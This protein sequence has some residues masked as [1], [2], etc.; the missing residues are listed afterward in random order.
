MI[1]N[2]INARR[3]KKDI[4]TLEENIVLLLAND[5]PEMAE[6][7]LHWIFGT[8]GQLADR[9][10]YILHQSTDNF[11]YERN[12]KKHK[13]H[14]FLIGVE[15]LNKQ[16][17]TYIP[18]RLTISNN[19]I[20]NISLPFNTTLRNEY[21]L[22]QLSI[23]NLHKE[24]FIL[25]NT[26]EIKLK[27]ILSNVSEEQKMLLEIEDTIE[28]ELDEKYYYTIMDMENGNYIAV[29]KMG[30]VFRLIHDHEEPAKKIFQNVQKL[31]EA[32]SGDKYELQKYLEQ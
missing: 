5:F 28:I 16:T 3:L 8:A 17:G 7:Y 30:N 23:N 26:D 29:N 6:N 21:E 9:T 20:Q 10:I 18:I 27:K 2:F 14:F 31:M 4:Q 32:Y 24:D 25:K 19:L 11:Y 15:L 1:F 13:Q 12:R 22:S